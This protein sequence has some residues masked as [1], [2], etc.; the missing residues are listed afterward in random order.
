[1]GWDAKIGELRRF[2]R[3]FSL[4]FVVMGTMLMTTAL[5]VGS[6]NNPSDPPPPPPPSPC[7]GSN[8]PVKYG[9][10]GES[11]I[12]YPDPQSSSG[13][14][15]LSPNDPNLD[16]FRVGITLQNLTGKGI[17]EGQFV[18]A[19]DGARCNESFYVF[20]GGSDF[21][22]AHSDP[23][24]QSVMAYALGDNY[25]SFLREN[26]SMLPAANTRVV[27]H[28]MQADNAY[29]QR[30][31][32]SS[33]QNFGRVCLGDSVETP[34][35][36]Y[37]DD[38]YVTVHEMQHGT[39]IE[40]YSSSLSL[41]Q[42]W[43]DE[44]GGLNEGVSDFVALMFLKDRVHANLDPRVFS[45]WALGQFVQGYSG[46]RGANKCPTY[47]PG[48]PNCSHFHTGAQGI[49]ASLGH[50]S[51]AYPDGLG[52]P[53]AN[54]FQGPGFLRAVHSGFSAQEEI[55]NVAPLISGALYDAFEAM[56]QVT[57]ESDARG[58]M[59]RWLHES[60]RHLP[61]PNSSLLSPVTYRG[62]IES[63]EAWSQTV[64]VSP[65]LKAAAMAAFEARGL[66][67]APQLS[68]GWA[69]VGSGTVQN[70][71]IKIVDNSVNLKAW[72]IA[73]GSDPA[74]VTQGVSTGLNG[75]LDRGE[76]VALWF[77]IRNTSALSVGGLNLSAQIMNDK[78]TFLN[79][80]TNIGA[81][82]DQVAQI[83]YYKI[84][85]TDAVQALSSSNAS[86]S[87]P[88]SNTY[89]GTNP[90]FSSSFRTALWLKGKSNLTSGDRIPID[91]TVHASGAPDEVLH[92][93]I[94]VP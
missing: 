11:L 61:K 42:F 15:A 94:V 1:M 52:W 74:Q 56:S 16:N 28:C 35:A 58:I 17:L 53:Y 77:D 9:S 6:C 2:A 18:E 26:A 82:S 44:A 30:F 29:F 7:S 73:M 83:Q 5:L 87:V 12:F 60:I 22:T 25:R 62:L 20:E 80:A 27:A 4:R 36:S 31:S 48:F 84:F 34:G 21:R 10:T 37:G 76:V 55:H 64:G 3:I 92:Y 91:V 51:Y 70:P 88:A 46:V 19:R 66:W 86:L 78:A 63:M 32:D 43:Y 47:D 39:T 69:Q 50:V 65:G 81:V 13:N 14:G 57:S 72:L 90:F 49:S 89:F 85:G 54:T 24:F 79:G 93:E 67:N 75:R 40:H 59:T 41:N 33:G 45:R 68:A 23:K 8:I 71:G 38:G